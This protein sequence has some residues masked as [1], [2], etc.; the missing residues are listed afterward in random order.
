MSRTKDGL[1][2]NEPMNP[3]TE[4]DYTI[5]RSGWLKLLDRTTV[6]VGKQIKRAKV[7]KCSDPF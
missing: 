1:L 7:Q 5:R 3:P 4:A 6:K 2:D